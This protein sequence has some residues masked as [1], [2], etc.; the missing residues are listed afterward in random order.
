[1]GITLGK[2]ASVSIDGNP[3]AGVRNV[4]FT[5]TART[6]D[7]EAYASRFVEVYSTGRDAS[8]SMECN[9]SEAIG[10]LLT[11]L[12]NGTEVS[13]SGGEGGFSFDAVI[14]S[15]SETAP[16]DGV[17]TYQIEAKMTR[18]GLRTS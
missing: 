9:D 4:T 15:V 14:T 7:I 18:T 11:A 10:D 6:I 3:V 5:S 2:D 17:V 12:N 16:I 13:V 8:V 1:M